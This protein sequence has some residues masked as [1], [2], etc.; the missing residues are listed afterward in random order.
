[1]S[2]PKFKKTILQSSF[3]AADGNDEPTTVKGRPE[4]DEPLAEGNDNM[5]GGNGGMNG[6][7]GMNGGMNGMN[8]LGKS[9]FQGSVY[10]SF[11]AQ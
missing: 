9:S 11:M 4:F 3:S 7:N 1:M 6:M 2:A 8:M 10:G 5:N